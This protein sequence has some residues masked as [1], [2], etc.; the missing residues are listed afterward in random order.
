MRSPQSGECGRGQWHRTG[1]IAIDN[2]D[3]VPVAGWAPFLLSPGVFAGR[4]DAR[5]LERCGYSILVFK[6]F[7]VRLL[8]VFR[9][10]SPLLKLKSSIPCPLAKVAGHV[11]AGAWLEEGMKSSSM[12]AS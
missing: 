11:Q 1:K 6:E 10:V 5:V 2:V 3:S 8:R 12:A 7:F 4:K 9:P